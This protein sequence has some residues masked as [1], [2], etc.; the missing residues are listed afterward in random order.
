[1]NLRKIIFTVF[2]VIAIIIILFVINKIE[3]TP[4]QI[5]AAAQPAGF[6]IPSP[7]S[8]AGTSAQTDKEIP[9]EKEYPKQVMVGLKS[10]SDLE[11][12]KQIIIDN[13]GK[14]IK[15]LKWPTKNV[16]IA[17]LP[18]RNSE[19]GI[20]KNSF[21]GKLVGGVGFSDFGNKLSGGIDYAEK[22]IKVPAQAINPI[23][24]GVARI[25]ADKVWNVSTGK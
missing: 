4:Q 10:W 15:T 20:L 5:P 2:C 14:I 6:E 7:E 13:G 23:D 1:M 9:I 12:A 21:W 19:Q 11:S 17:V 22:D 24:W 3:T 25:K 18:D 8:P 16:I